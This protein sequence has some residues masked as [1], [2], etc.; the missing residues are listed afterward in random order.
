MDLFGWNTP[1]KL[2]SAVTLCGVV[3][4]TAP[5]HLRQ[6]RGFRHAEAKGDIPGISLLRFRLV[7]DTINPM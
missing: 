2:N 3:D 6:N 7:I 1:L 5:K 4:T